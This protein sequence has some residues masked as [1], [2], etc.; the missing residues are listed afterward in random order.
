MQYNYLWGAGLIIIGL[1]L[2]FAG[3][4]FVNATLFLVGSVAVAAI[5][6]FFTFSL[7]ENRN[8]KPKEYVEWIIVAA[9][10]LFGI[11]IGSLLVK[12]RKI[13]VGILAGWGGVMIGFI[14]T[15]MFANSITSKVWYYAIIAGCAV[16]LFIVAI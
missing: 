11:A 9:F 7:I 10:I 12:Y 14:I 16:I 3:N 6:L 8:S 13:G 1:I 4:K 2:A 5:G 15:T